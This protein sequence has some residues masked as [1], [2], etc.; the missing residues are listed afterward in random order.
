[1]LVWG[2]YECVFLRTD[3]FTNRESHDFLK[4]VQVP[5]TYCCQHLVAQHSKDLFIPLEKIIKY[6]FLEFSH[7]STTWIWKNG[8]QTR[9]KWMTNYRLM[10]VIGGGNLNIDLTIEISCIFISE[11]LKRKQM[12]FDAHS[13]VNKMKLFSV[14]N[15]FGCQFSHFHCVLNDHLIIHS[16]NVFGQG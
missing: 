2:A 9:T 8:W 10:V 14:I 13:C 1:M 5:A 6:Y 7:Q 11:Q 12:Y 16:I 3:W 4:I 15:H